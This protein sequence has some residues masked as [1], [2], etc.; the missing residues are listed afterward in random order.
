VIIQLV[1]HC[2]LRRC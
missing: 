2:Y 1:I